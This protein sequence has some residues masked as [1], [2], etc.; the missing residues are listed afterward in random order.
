MLTASSR[1]KYVMVRN[2]LG[3][4]GWN[5]NSRIR[6][7]YIHPSHHPGGSLRSLVGLIRMLP[8]SVEC[9][10]LTTTA[11]TEVVSQYGPVIG[12]CGVPVFDHSRAGYYRG[13]RWCILFREL[14]Y[15]P[16]FIVSI[17]R[18]R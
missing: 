11:V 13:L 4:G 12:C 17:L 8:P 10:F 1:R 14:L 3:P 2:V 6:V 16:C 7:L 15:T 5:P 9:R 18:A